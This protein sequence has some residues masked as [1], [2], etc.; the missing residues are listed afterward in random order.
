MEVIVY[1]CSYRSLW[2]CL[3]APHQCHVAMTLD[4]ADLYEP[5]GCLGMLTTHQRGD[6]HGSGYLELC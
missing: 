4:A 2:F 1:P 6:E 3:A 5:S